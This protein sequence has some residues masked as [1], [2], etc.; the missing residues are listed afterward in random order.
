M[1]VLLKIPDFSEADFYNH[2][3]ISFLKHVFIFF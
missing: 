1:Q 2:L 3:V